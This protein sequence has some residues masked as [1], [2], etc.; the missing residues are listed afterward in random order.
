MFRA[1]KLSFAVKLLVFSGH[2]FQKL[3]KILFRLI[4]LG[5]T[6]SRIIIKDLT[7]CS[8]ALASFKGHF[9]VKGQ[10][11]KTFFMAITREY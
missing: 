6:T 2:F 10:R 4:T 5:L 7:S 9:M 3:G 1:F 8:E 11:Y